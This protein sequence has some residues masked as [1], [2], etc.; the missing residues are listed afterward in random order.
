MEE[1]RAKERALEKEYYEDDNGKRKAWVDEEVR[2]KNAARMEAEA[3]KPA[4]PAYRPTFNGEWVCT[5]VQGDW[6]EFLRL[7][8]LP[9]FQ[10]KLAK[11]RQW[12]VGVAEQRIFLPPDKSRIELH[13]HTKVP[14]YTT[15]TDEEAD[16]NGVRP[17]SFSE[18]IVYRIDGNHQEMAYA[19]LKGVGSLA[20]EGTELVARMDLDALGK[21]RQ[22]H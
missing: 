7:M 22:P 1:Q 16:E 17:D 13:N 6:D 2:K 12:G 19:G 9:E 10:R 15:Y 3:E 20:W 4:P 5:G 18:S 14:A 8:G 21:V 11:A